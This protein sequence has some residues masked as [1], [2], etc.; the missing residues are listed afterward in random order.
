M[1]NIRKQSFIS[2]TDDGKDRVVAEIY[3]DDVT[4]LPTVDGIDGYELEQGSIAYITH[5]GEL[6]VMD[7]N[8]T[9][10]NSEDGS[11]PA[12]QETVTLR[13]TATQSELQAEAKTADLSGENN[14][15]GDINDKYA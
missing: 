12:T 4:E 8:G 3:V 1:I 15:E 5:S 14:E 2:F 9:W 13:K 7:G 10:Y 6:Y 11:T